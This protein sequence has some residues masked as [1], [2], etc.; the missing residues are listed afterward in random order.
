[1]GTLAYNVDPEHALRIHA[2]YELAKRFAGNDAG[3]IVFDHMSFTDPGFVPS[4]V[5]KDINGSLTSTYEGAD[6]QS[7]LPARAPTWS[8]LP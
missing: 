4:K 5:H 2:R 7:E 3:D 1:M 6:T 8:D